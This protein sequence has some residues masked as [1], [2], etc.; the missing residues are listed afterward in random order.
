M[1][2]VESEA[3]VNWFKLCRK[4]C[5]IANQNQPFTPIGGSGLTVEIDETAIWSRKYHRGRVLRKQTHWI[6]T[7]ICRETKRVFIIPVMT[8]GDRTLVPLIKKYV[9]EP[10]IEGKEQLTIYSDGWHAYSGLG[11]LGYI[12]GIVIHKRNFLNPQNRNIHTQ[13]VER[14]NLSLKKFL[15]ANSCTALLDSHIHQFLYFR[16]FKKLPVGEIFREFI[17]DIIKVYPGYGKI[18]LKE[19]VNSYI[20]PH[21]HEG[22]IC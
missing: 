8:R 4:V 10:I 6:F 11:G 21:I 15:P 3:V 16:R 13:T 14:L 7:G 1:T 20:T 2:G 12:H 22:L 5:K 19:F 18:G 9:G 17:S